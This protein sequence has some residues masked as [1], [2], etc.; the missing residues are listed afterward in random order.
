MYIYTYNIYIYLYGAC[1]K[2][3]LLHVV[4]YASAWPRWP[5][6]RHDILN[7]QVEDKATV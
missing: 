4:G 1:G 5:K 7:V 2:S 6:G 3:V